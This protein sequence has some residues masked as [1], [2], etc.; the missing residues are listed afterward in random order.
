MK[1][2]LAAVCEECFRVTTTL[3]AN[4]RKFHEYRCGHCGG[5]LAHTF[6]TCDIHGEVT[7]DLSPG[8]AGRILD[9][10]I[11]DPCR[12]DQRESRKGKIAMLL[13]LLFVV[14][15]VAALSAC[16]PKRSANT[17]VELMAP[18]SEVHKITPAVY[19]H[20]FY[21][22]DGVR[23]VTAIVSDFRG[24]ALSCEWGTKNKA[25]GE[26]SSPIMLAERTVTWL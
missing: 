4:L 17:N 1:N 6:L 14:L 18:R 20:V 9:Y 25:P 19:A 5:L 2:Q 26:V 21:L 13:G 3:E 12:E 24:V 15:V 8:E 22:N 16:A 11:C 7:H 23:C 10:G